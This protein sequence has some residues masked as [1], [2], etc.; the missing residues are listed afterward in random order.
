[1][2]GSG[3]SP[4]LYEDLV[5]FVHDTNRSDSIC[6]ALDK[7]TGA[8]VWRR[9]RPKAM[10]WSSPVVVRVDDHDELL[11]A[12]G[13]TVR[14]YDP[15]GGDELWVLDGPTHEV[16]PSLVVGERLVYSASGRQG[17]TIA[18]VPGGRGNITAERTQWRTTRGG[19]HV[20]SPVLVA[21]R[22]YS[23]NDTGVA[24]CLN[25]ETGKVLWQA[26]VSD[27]FSASP[28]AVGDRLYCAAES[29]AVYVLA[30]GE[31]FAVLATNRLEGG[32]LASPAVIDGRVYL[33]TTTALYCLGAK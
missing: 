5:L 19:P 17:P 6:L 3:S 20:P 24:T 10:G 13:K 15:R 8:E 1:M 2:W 18:F 33:R 4:I 21:G 9:E 12:G 31:K 30:A 25:A 29:G 11:Y 7:K 16:I 28:V 22:L 27:E 26:R 23:V 14:G 32:I